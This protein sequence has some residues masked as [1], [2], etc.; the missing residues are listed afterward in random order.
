MEDAFAL[1][2]ISVRALKLPCKHRRDLFGSLSMAPKASQHSVKKS[3]MK[4][5]DRTPT[6][7]CKLGCAWADIT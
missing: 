4:T 6:P 3:S 5:E 1:N 7:A 2:P